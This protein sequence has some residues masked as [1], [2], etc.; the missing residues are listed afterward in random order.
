MWKECPAEARQRE[1]DGSE[2]DTSDDETLD[3]HGEPRKKLSLLR[4]S[5]GD[6]YFGDPAEV[7]KHLNVARYAAEMPLIPL[8]EL[9][10]SA[11][12]HPRFPEFRWLLHTRRVKTKKM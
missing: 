3:Q 8:E 9:H 7:N 11:I 5:D 2:T 1:A 6:Y 12:Q 4:D 10:A